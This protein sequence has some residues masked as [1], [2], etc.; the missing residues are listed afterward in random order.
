VDLSGKTILLTGGTGSFGTAFTARVL[1]AYP[2][3]IV[4]LFSRDEL[5][6]SEARTRFGDERVRYLIGDVRDRRRLTRAAQGASIIV[7]AAAMKQVAACEYNP[8]EAVNTN[9][10][11]AQNVVDAA[12]DA[13]VERVVALS[14]DKAVNP[15]NLYG[16]TKLCAEKIVVQGNAYGASSTRLACVR[17]GNVVGS[18]GSVVPIFQHQAQEGHLTITDK[19]MTRFWITLDQAVDLVFGAINNLEGGEIFIPKIPS[20]RVTDLARVI[21]PGT[22]HTVVGIRP[23]E[24]LHEVL[25]TDSEAANTWDIGDA[26][27]LL[28]QHQ[29]WPTS[30]RWKLEGTKVKEGFTYSSDTNPW[31]L[32]ED[33]LRNLLE[34]VP[35]DRRGARAHMLVPVLSI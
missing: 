19:R 18:R 30:G 17:Y 34:S 28:P 13:R 23:G 31:W 5:K 10:L 20:M 6:Q 11:G 33:G 7:H 24:K 22:P 16:A 8:F 3:T 12:I 29:T 9:V 27:V 2:D 4:R 15:F 35:V 32:D 21:A 14:T 25:L 26:F 1:E